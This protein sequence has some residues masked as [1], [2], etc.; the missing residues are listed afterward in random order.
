MASL[1]EFR[2]GR[3]CPR[4]NMRSPSALRLFKILFGISSWSTT[5]TKSGSR[6]RRVL[7]PALSTISQFCFAVVAAIRRV[8]SSSAISSC[9]HK[10]YICRF[11]HVSQRDTKK[12]GMYTGNVKCIFFY[13]R[14]I[15]YLSIISNNSF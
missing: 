7:L 10:D 4:T 13:E 1:G 12:S 5:T 2:L 11:E 9:F 8:L 3:R 14:F 15:I 6:T